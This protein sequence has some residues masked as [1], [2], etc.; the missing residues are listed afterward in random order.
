MDLPPLSASRR[1]QQQ[2]AAA[3]TNAHL[4][5]PVQKKSD[6]GGKSVHKCPGKKGQQQWMNIEAV[7]ACST[8]LLPFLTALFVAEKWPAT[9]HAKKQKQKASSAAVET[10]TRVSC[11]TFHGEERNAGRSAHNPHRHPQSCLVAS[12]PLFGPRCIP[13]RLARESH[14]RRMPSPCTQRTQD[15]ATR[16]PNDHLTAMPF[17]YLMDRAPLAAG[18][19]TQNKQHNALRSCEG[20]R[21]NT[22][23]A[24]QT[25][26][27]LPFATT[28]LKWSGVFSCFSTV[29][30][31]TRAIWPYHMIALHRCQRQLNPQRP[32]PARLHKHAGMLQ[33]RI[34]VRRGVARR[35][36][37]APFALR[38]RRAVLLHAPGPPRH[39]LK[40]RKQMGVGRQS[41]VS[42]QLLL[43][44]LFQLVGA[45]RSHKQQEKTQTHW[46][47]HRGI[48][49]QMPHALQVF[50]EGFV[51]NGDVL[52]HLPHLRQSFLPVL[53]QKPRAK[54]DV[55][56]QSG[57]PLPKLRRSPHRTA[58]LR[59]I[60]LRLHALRQSRVIR[61]G[62][63][64]R[65]RKLLHA[66]RKKTMTVGA[67]VHIFL[68]NYCRFESAP[69][70]FPQVRSY[71]F[72]PS[73]IR[74]SSRH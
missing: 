36:T 37:R 2:S 29:L 43:L 34:P 59:K 64:Q 24:T 48:P 5:P 22:A 71:T 72:F 12:V 26:M 17:G 3:L 66:L 4:L 18:H 33:K 41:T 30:A 20:N 58:Q 56:R 61:V 1:G 60:G 6:H 8:N 32:I 15:A 42:D 46:P 44:D 39:M 9:A 45:A 55:Q 25:R 52:F 28:P 11:K 7:G 16:F 69:R 65:H 63:F 14:C 62:F 49:R 73:G 10:H 50:P 31:T 67:P 51:P 70:Q 38:R 27:I 23:T 74:S 53:C 19:T 54:I 47:G 68:I 35:G 13:V 40:V 57:L 21:P